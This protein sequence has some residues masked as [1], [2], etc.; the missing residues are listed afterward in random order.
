MNNINGAVEEGSSKITLLFQNGQGMTLEGG[1]AKAVIEYI[2]EQATV[3]RV[4]NIITP[5]GLIK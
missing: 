1:E 2:K 5:K 3:L 4:I